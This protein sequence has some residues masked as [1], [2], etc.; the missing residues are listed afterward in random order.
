[1]PIPLLLLG[2]AANGV[3]AQSE[4]AGPATA[5]TPP[6]EPTATAD[7]D[8]E[9]VVEGDVPNE[10]RRVCEMRTTTGSIMPKRVCRTV[11]QRE[12][13]REAAREAMERIS[14]DREA[15]TLVQEVNGTGA[16]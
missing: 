10:R 15:R 1:M 11:G 14:R 13:E 3:V 9:I 6:A 2:I 7:D 16:P 8:P 5:V 4:P 12:G